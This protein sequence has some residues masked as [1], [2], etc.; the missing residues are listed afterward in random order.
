MFLTIQDKDD[1]FIVRSFH[2]RNIG[3]RYNVI[4]MHEAIRDVKPFE[5][6]VII[7]VP[8]KDRSTLIKK[9]ALP[10]I[11]PTVM[12]VN[13]WIARYAFNSRDYKLK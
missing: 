3:D 13:I 12:E 4:K 7:K 5:N 2:N 9:D 10:K 6:E 1:F 11:E 8:V